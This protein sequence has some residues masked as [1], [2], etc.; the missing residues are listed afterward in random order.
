MA[1]GIKGFPIKPDDLGLIPKT[2]TVEGKNQLLRL[3]LASIH[4]LCHV[5]AYTC[6]HICTHKVNKTFK[7]KTGQIKQPMSAD[8]MIT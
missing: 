3:S 1:E 7:K 4:M 2:H 6:A 5:C 8:D